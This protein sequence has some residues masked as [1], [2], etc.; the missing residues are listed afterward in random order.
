MSVATDPLTAAGLTAA[1]LTAAELTA[2]ADVRLR[3]PAFYDDPYP[4]YAWLREHAPVVWSEQ[5]GAWVVSRAADVEAVLRDPAH[6]S[7][8]GRI[9]YLLESLAPDVRSE[10]ALLERHYRV[11]IAHVD[12][13]AHTRLRALVAPW[14]LPRHM[15]ALRPRITALAEEL[16]RAAAARAATDGDVL[17]LMESIA[18]PLPAL[19]VM[20]LLGAPPAHAEAY[21]RW[22][23][24]IN[25]LFAA[26][27]KT[28]AAAAARAQKAL[29]EMRAAI[30]ELVAT[31]RRVPSDDLVGRLVR[32]EAEGDRLSDDELISTCVT[33]FVAGHETTTHLIGNG[34]VALLRNPAQ[35]ARLRAEPALIPAAC[36][37]L[38]RFDPPVQR[39]WR[40]ATSDRELGGQQIG[41]G[42]MVL[43][44]IGAA[45]RD[46]ALVAAGEQLDVARR[47]SR[48]LGFGVGI[49]FCLGA[50]LARIEVPV[51]L[52]AIL[53]RWPQIE[54]VEE[55]PLRWRRD[56][57]LRGLDA[58]PVRVAGAQLASD[59]AARD[60]AGD[61]ANK[62]ANNAAHSPTAS[63]GT[64]Q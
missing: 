55:P 41:K 12:P 56:L 20:E 38:L 64:L 10:A 42:Q 7:S 33:L 46:P 3:N 35:L 57:A 34:M 15:E 37:E 27:G 11:G 50:P 47:D 24:E 9:H 52:A 58:L 43:L 39:S 44:L 18:Y 14:F 54:L 6:Y 22:A 36:E 53:R 29:A 63:R 19:V 1:E 61:A 31:R 2:A 48:H 5:L 13:P 51:A 49:H 4:A 32:A 21:R 25:L 45:N 59:D 16:V 40:I 26:G 17:D 28:T 23:L 62:V 8:A 30:G 60:A